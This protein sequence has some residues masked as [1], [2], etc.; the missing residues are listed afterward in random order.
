MKTDS[1]IRGLRRALLAWYP[2]RKGE[3]ALVLGE[4]ADLFTERM[5]RFYSQVDFEEKTDGHYDCIVAMD[6]LEQTEDAGGFLHRLHQMLAPDGVLLLGTR[7]RFGLHYL[8]GGIDESVELPFENLRREGSG[9]CRLFSRNQLGSILENAGFSTFFYYPLPDGGFPQVVFSDAYLP[10]DRISDRV[11]CYDLWDSPFVAVE[12]EQYA[13]MIRENA[14]PLA[15]N[16]FL[17]ECHRKEWQRQP[18]EKRAVFAALSADRGEEHGFATVLYD[19]ETAGKHALSAAGIP[20]LRACFENVERLKKRGLL[21]VPQDLAVGAVAIYMPFIHETPLMTYLRRV[22]S[23]K[24]TAAF[25][26]VFDRIWGDVLRSSDLG[27]ISEEEA[28]KE[29]KTE[30]EDL[31]PI[32][33]RALIDMIP[34][35]AFHTGEQIRYYDQEFTVENCP[36]LYVMYRALFY[37][38]LHIPETESLIPLEQAKNHFGLEKLWDVFAAREKAFV[39]DNRNWEKYKSLYDAMWVDRKKI[40]ERR[41][42]LAENAFSKKKYHI[43]LLMGVFDLFHIGHLNLI[44]RA[45]DQ[46]DY[47]R[48]GVL[49]DELVMKFKNIYPTI[50]LK[51]R[52]EI[53]ASVR[54]VDEVVVIDKDPSR[55]EEW[56]KRPFDCF[57]SGDDY[58]GNSYWDW[59]KKELQKLGSDIQFFPYTKEQSSSKIRAELKEKK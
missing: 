4:D 1:N 10:K 22:L 28:L 42:W 59:E 53:L 37:T 44:R 54:Y 33:Q 5:S 23:Q 7:N 17:V 19:D 38:W 2:F 40:G 26:S 15:G 3:R 48:V 50:P 58:A 56:H 12:E 55:I 35:N 25:M 57:F 49:S 43:G 41:R 6:V 34:L 16:Y 20:A 8:C 45:K 46:C 47:L 21:T 36:A 11:M 13:A 29:W 32:L 9:S 24:D 39:S 27:T 14:L 52:M 30:P 31:G 18:E 51:E